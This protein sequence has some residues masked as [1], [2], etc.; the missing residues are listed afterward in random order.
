MAKSN[1]QDFSNPLDAGKEYLRLKDEEGVS[2]PDIARQFNVSIPAV[3]KYIQLAECDKR[4][5]NYIIKGDITATKVIAILHKHP[6][7]S[8][9]AK[10]TAEVKARKKKL[11]RLEKE[12]LTKMTVKR[13][14]QEVSK[15][16]EA[17]K[18]NTPKAQFLKEIAQHLTSGASVEQLLSL[19]RA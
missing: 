9:L 18:L 14:L 17:K 13:R 6:K 8:V 4:I 3:Y 16:I 11:K 1:K 19:T 12:G 7:G 15:E 10:V 5:Q 2:V